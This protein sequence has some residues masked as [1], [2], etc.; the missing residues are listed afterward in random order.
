MCAFT[1]T[2]VSPVTEAT[3]CVTKKT[4]YITVAHHRF[5][6]CFISPTEYPYSVLTGGHFRLS[7]KG[8]QCSQELNV[9]F[10]FT[11]EEGKPCLNAHIQINTYP[12]ILPHEI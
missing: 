5:N 2:L 1:D 7:K 8:M 12:N 6:V 10:C 11:V 3:G 4:Y 9:G